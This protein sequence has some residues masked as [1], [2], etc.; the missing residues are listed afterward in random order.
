MSGL[1]VGHRLPVVVRRV[2][3]VQV[4]WVGGQFNTMGIKTV[5]YFLSDP[6]E[7]PP[8]HDAYYGEII[9]RLPD[10][11]ACYE[12]PE[13]APPVSPLPAER[14]S[15]ITFGGLNKTN[16]LTIA[17]WS[18]CLNTV[19]RSR[20]ILKSDSFEHTGTIRRVK[21][22]FGNHGIDEERI[23]CRNFTP[24]PDLFEAYHDIDIALDPHPYSGCLTTCEALWMGVP[25]V[26]LPR[27][28]FAGRHSASFLTSVGLQD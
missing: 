24:H 17:L 25:V 21:N 11:C 20:L 5:D 1:A 18:R 14:R 22:L 9:Y 26:T 16:K 8:E 15:Y 2:A 4:K 23:E 7:S 27:P 12:P 6:V 3:S 19:P 13:N 28:T 10:V